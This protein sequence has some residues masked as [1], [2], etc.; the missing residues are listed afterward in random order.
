[1]QKTASIGIAITVWLATTVAAQTP[2]AQVVVASRDTG[3]VQTRLVFGDVQT[4][5]MQSVSGFPSDG[6]APLEVAVDPLNR[7]IVLALDDGA[8]TRVIRL[9]LSGTTV[10]TERFLADVPGRAVSLTL[11]YPGDV[12]VLTGG[13]AGALYSVPRNG[14]APSVVAPF[15]RATAMTKLRYLD[16]VVMITQSASTSPP[17]DPALAIVN[18]ESG[19]IAT[20]PWPGYNPSPITGII[21]LPS[22]LPRQHI[23]HADGTVGQSLGF[24]TP[25]P[26]QLTPALP[27]GAT[28]AAGPEATNSQFYFLGDDSHP[29][30]IEVP[31]PGPQLPY[32]ARV[33][34]LPGVPVDFDF[35][36]RPDGI[37]NFFGRVCGAT[38]QPIISVVNQQTTPS[39]NFGFGVFSATPGIAALFVLG[40]NEQQTFG[41]PLPITLASGCQ[42]LVSL[43]VGIGHTIDA[44][45]A[46]FQPVPIPNLPSL[47]GQSI[48]A[49]WVLATPVG[50]AVTQG[51]AVQIGN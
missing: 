2:H 35:A 38:T 10:V 17:A 47:I 24:G 49:Q 6:L 14:G 43:D 45:G 28:M 22:T 8:T 50:F 31:F 33:G 37:I 26:Q 46:A 51:A 16:A 20:Y 23:T 13:P 39:P 1:M 34:P 9:G 36:P 12:F 3:P 4:G 19:P 21:D 15:P 42:L 32:M 44:Q 30:L 27:S 11:G 40:G 7:D 25:T 5:A 41:V 29:F 18:V 48:Y